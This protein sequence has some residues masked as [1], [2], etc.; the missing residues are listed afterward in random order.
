MEGYNLSLISPEA[1]KEALPLVYDGFEDVKISL[2]KYSENLT[3][4][5]ENDKKYVLRIYR[6]GYHDPDE[7][8]GEVLWQARLRNDTDIRLAAV[9][10]GKD[11]Q[12]IQ[13]VTI[14]GN[15]Y[16]LT[17]FEF[18]PGK[19]LGNLSKDDL[20][21]Y[22]EKIGEITAKLHNHVL[23]WKES[24][25]LKRF[26]WNY[27]DLIGSN[28]RWGNYTEMKNL[29][30]EEVTSYTQATQII[31]KRLNNYGKGEQRYGLI[32]SDLNLNNI[33]IDGDD[34]YVLDFDDCGFGWFMYDLSTTVLEYF[35][36]T[37]QSCLASLLS[38]YEK[39]RTLSKSDREELETFIILRKIVRVGWIATHIDNDTVKKIN[40][41]YYAET[42]AL[43]SE[44]CKKMNSLDEG[45]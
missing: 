5:L 45:V 4:L 37:L 28:A 34:I 31:E 44:Y 42:A 8:Y 26:T 11:C 22:M 23:H 15:K 18:V 32:H 25:K 39:Y 10:R 35:G 21:Y 2:L 19:V 6:P 36:E 33:L 29:T 38:G 1:I 27:E 13:A 7:L 16:Y 40:P 9:I 3:Y 43:A 20:Y 17:M 14:G 30:E 24:A 41:D 12:L